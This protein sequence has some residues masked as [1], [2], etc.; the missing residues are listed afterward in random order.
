M[1]ADILNFIAVSS[2]TLYGV[3]GVVRQKMLIERI[4]AV[5]GYNSHKEIDFGSKLALPALLADFRVMI[6]DY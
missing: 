1:N 3:R 5:S 4:G 6:I 2:Y